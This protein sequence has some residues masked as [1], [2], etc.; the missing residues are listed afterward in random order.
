MKKIKGDF[1]FINDNER[2]QLEIPDLIFKINKD[3]I[4]EEK[5]EE[6]TS[7]VKLQER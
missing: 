1:S 5:V 7:S 2:K 4:A 3:L 6:K